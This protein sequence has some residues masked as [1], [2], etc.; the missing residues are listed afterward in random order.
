MSVTRSFAPTSLLLG[1]FVIGTAIIGPSGMLTELSS[2]LG[3]SI[4]DAGLL[5][6]FGA[7][8]L[9]ICSPLSA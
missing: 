9:C 3:V 8:M 5:I 4:R 7:V 6:T 1:N 2:G